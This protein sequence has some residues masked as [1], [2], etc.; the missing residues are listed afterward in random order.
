MKITESTSIPGLGGCVGVYT[1][2]SH[3]HVLCFHVCNHR[4]ICGG[5]K[6]CSIYNME[7]FKK[8]SNKSVYL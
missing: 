8:I 7:H 6:N 4:T 5:G 3:T 2:T 1:Y